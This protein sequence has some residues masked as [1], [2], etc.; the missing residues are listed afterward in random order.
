MNET[1]YFGAIDK[2]AKE[3]GLDTDLVLAVCQHES[4]LNP[5]AVRFE[6]K[7]KYILNP[8]EYAKALRITIET[9]ITLQ[10]MSWGCMQVMGAVARELGF[11]EHLTKLTGVE[12]GLEFGCKKLKSCFDKYG[13]NLTLV[14]SAYNAGS[15]RLVNGV[16]VNQQYVNSVLGHLTPK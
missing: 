10:K 7:F 6:P 3:H 13:D 11:M 14:L 2:A 15:P 8:V 16:L 4:G 5:Y 1:I 12:L 9:E